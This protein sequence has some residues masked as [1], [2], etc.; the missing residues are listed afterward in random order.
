[1]VELADIFRRHGPE[2]RKLYKD[3]ILPSHRRAMRDIENCRTETMGGHVYVCEDDACKEYV[4]SYHSC[5]NRH[6]NR[7]QNDQSEVWLARQREK[8]LPVPYFLVTPTLPEE[9]REIARSNQK[10]VYDILFKSSAEALMTLVKD[11]RFIGG[12]IGMTGVMHTWDKKI[13]YHVHIHYLVPGGGLSPDRTKWL[14]AKQ[15]FLVRFEPLGVL[16]KAKFRDALKKAGLFDA[17]NSAVWKKNWGMHI[18]PVGTGKE[19]AVYLARY[20][21]RVA[22]TNNRLVKLEDDTVTYRCKDSKTR[23]WYLRTLPALTFIHQ[24]LQHVLPKGFQKVRYYGLFSNKKR[25]LLAVA[26]YVLRARV[27]EVVVKARPQMRCPK[28]GNTLRLVGKISRHPRGPPERLR[29]AER[30]GFN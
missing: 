30:V 16:F 7:C 18:E 12:D 2:Y 21:F 10:T 3:S 13:G 20:V 5:K 22:I 19:A 8:I 4:F 28:C 27:K 14:P 17:V 25:N 6:C 24:F 11:P 26:R 1:M 9:L 23:K 29:L 15:D